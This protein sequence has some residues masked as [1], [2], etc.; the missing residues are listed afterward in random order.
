MSALRVLSFLGQAARPHYEAVAALVA[1]RAGVEVAPLAEPGLE[2]LGASAA[3]GETALLFVCGLP[4]VRARDAG[5]PVEPLVAP[6]AAGSDRPEY[7]ADLVLRDGLAAQSADD[8]VAPR[9][10]YNGDD[11]MS[12]WVLPRSELAPRGLVPRLYGSTVCSGSHRASIAMLVAAEADC[13]AI[14]SMVLA[15]EARADPRVAALRVVERL[16]PAPSPPIVLAGGPATLAAALRKA[17]CEL[18]RDPAGAKA[19][20]LGLIDR[21]EPVEDSDYDPIRAAESACAR[22]TVESD[23]TRRPL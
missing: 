19:L 6:V 11:S 14:D 5:A 20:A 3:G 16:G 17:L 18:H 4:Y 2:A 1:A 21:F 8:L 23:G 9:M 12:G 7:F 22:L 10:A 15:L 13:A